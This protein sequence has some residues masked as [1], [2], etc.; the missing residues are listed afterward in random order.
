MCARACVCVRVRVCVCVCV[1]VYMH[2]CM[3]HVNVEWS[4]GMTIYTTV[5]RLTLN[6]GG[7][8]VSA[9]LGLYRG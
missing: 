2:A 6:Q 3:C 5:Q 4:D 9:I 1:R 8:E 7:G